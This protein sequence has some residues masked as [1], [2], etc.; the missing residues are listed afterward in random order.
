MKNNKKGKNTGENEL[1][2]LRKEINE[3]DNQITDLLEERFVL[4]RNIGVWKKKNKLPILDRTR[5][6]A[7]I[8]DRCNKSKL[9]RDF[10]KSLFE[11]IFKESRRIQGKI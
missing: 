2:S 5:E 4:S 8:Q 9:N 11:L 10:V 1:L 7:I 6:K 3:V